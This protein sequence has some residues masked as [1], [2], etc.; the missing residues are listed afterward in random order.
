MPYRDTVQNFFVFIILTANS[1]LTT[2]AASS[3]NEPFFLAPNSTQKTITPPTRE[4]ISPPPQQEIHEHTT[5]VSYDPQLNAPQENKPDIVSMPRMHFAGPDCDEQKF[6]YT[7]ENQMGTTVQNENTQC[8]NKLFSL[9]GTSAYYTF[10]ESKMIAVA[11]QFKRLAENYNANRP[12]GIDSVIL[13]LRAGYYVQYYQPQDV[14]TYGQSLKGVMQQ[15]LTAFFRNPHAWQD[16]QTNS[17]IL[18]EAFTLID[19][20]RE[21]ALFLPVIRRALRLY[22]SQ[23]WNNSQFMGRAVNSV[24]TVLFRGHYL[25]NFVQKVKNDLRILSALK[26]FHDQNTHLLGTDNEYLLSNA[27]RELARF[28]QHTGSIKNRVKPLLVDILNQYNMGGSGA[29]IWVGVA[30]MVDYYDRNRCADYNIC[31]FKAQLTNNIL[32]ISH[33]CNAYIKIRAQKIT[34]AQLDNVCQDIFTQEAYFHRKLATNQQPVDNDYNETLQVNIFDSSR[35]YKAYAGILFDIST[36]NGGMYLEGDPEISGNQANFVAYRAEWLNSFHVWN[37]KHETVHYLDGRYNLHGK[38]S[39][40]PAN[41]VWWSEGLAEYISKKDDNAKAI[42]VQK[43]QR[44]DLERLFQTSYQSGAEQ[45]Y[46]GGY[47]AVRFMFEIFPDEVTTLLDYMRNGDFDSFT[48]HLARIDSYYDSDFQSWFQ[49]ISDPNYVPDSQENELDNNGNTNI[50]TGKTDES[51]N[52]TDVNTDEE[53][54]EDSH[55]KYPSNDKPK[56]VFALDETNLASDDRIYK[57]IYLPNDVEHVW[58]EMDGGE[59]DADVFINLTSWATPEDY[60]YSSRANGNREL[61][62][63]NYVNGQQYLYITLN[64]HQAFSNV[65]L[66]VSYEEV[67]K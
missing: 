47:L 37:L 61:I 13:F 44:Y 7:P 28:L 19:S 20:A 53:N 46:R 58:I 52:N 26:R 38:F 39:D 12:N 67:V 31:N 50:N 30:E 10:K 45:V 40:Y 57:A 42:Q 2:Q 64:A 17:H 49:T 5:H 34:Q 54:T 60:S 15:A 63:I 6:T 48:Q 24:F 43:D 23:H 25:D 56:R 66:K 4:L 32:S 9:T 11:R 51:T 41:S 33:Q 29:S 59:G 27:V 65:S 14:G 35:D 3:N 21:N 55:T 16:N 1:V 8:I 36:D 18:G 62:S 22:N